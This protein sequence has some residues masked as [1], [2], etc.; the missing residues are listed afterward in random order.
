MQAVRVFLLFVFTSFGFGP[1]LFAVPF[2]LTA[3]TSAFGPWQISCAGASDGSIDLQISGAVLPLNI[4][5]S[6][7]AVTEDRSGLTAGQYTVTVTDSSGQVESLSINLN[8]PP[9]L[10]IAVDSIRPASCPLVKTGF[11]RISVSGGVSPYAYAWSD[12][13]TDEDND[14]LR[15]GVYTVTVSDANG[16]STTLQ[17]SVNSYPPISVQDS[18][19]PASCFGFAD[20]SID[21]GVSGGL[22]PYRYLWST[23][24][25]TQDISGLVSGTYTITVRYGGGCRDTL[26]F[27][28]TEPD[29]ILMNATVNGISCAGNSDGSVVLSPTGGN[30]PYTFLW[31]DGSTT[32]SLN[33]LASGTYGVTLVDQKNCTLAD[34]FFVNEPLPL[35][36]NAG[37][38]RI[39]C[40][41]TLQLN[42]VLP[43]GATGSWSA[44]SNTSVIFSN[45]SL[46][47]ALVYG[48]STGV[49]T[50][51]W[52]VSL[53]SCD[54]SDTLYVIRRSDVDCNPQ[55]NLPNAITPNNDGFNDAYFV[56]DEDDFPKLELT[57]Y[58]RAGQLLFRAL[59]YR[60]DWFGQ[61]DSGTPLPAGTY[62]V[63]VKTAAGIVHNT[64]VDLIR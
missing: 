15:Q 46:P 3:S 48:F 7:G 59:P 35:V 2:Q 53:P 39:T 61:D 44:P 37:S 10:L 57:V 63:R 5:W 56:G 31:V 16:C 33:G 58:D 20:G 64:F 29:S 49:L 51:V 12:G 36:A 26:D 42:A 30:P 32:A 8:E 22:A 28:V 6:D 47:D 55:I 60:N 62:Y 14:S 38:D 40:N 18:V 9:T 11:I 45:A 21:I 1:A 43:S 24:S 54:A 23:G 50:L 25:T 27:F 17:D 52:T 34:S 19:T 4:V 41:D 13:S